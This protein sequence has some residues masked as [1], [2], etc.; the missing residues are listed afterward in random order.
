MNI[1]TGSMDRGLWGA[2]VDRFIS[3]LSSYDFPGGR[4]D[5]RENVKFVG[6]AIPRFVHGTFPESGCALAVEFKKFFMDEWTGE[7]FARE[8][9]TITSAL[10]ACLPGLLEALITVSGR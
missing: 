5:V 1:G 8:H 2:L 10:R 9:A 4:L 7:C 6:R 3:D